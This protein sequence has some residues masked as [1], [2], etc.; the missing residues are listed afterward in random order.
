MPEAP[1]HEHSDPLPAE[2]KVGG[3]T[4]TVHGSLISSISQTAPMDGGPDKPLGGWAGARH[5][6]VASA[7]TTSEH[8][9]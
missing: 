7:P 6:Q 1:V 3:A 5:R 2:D 9:T 4:D 8:A